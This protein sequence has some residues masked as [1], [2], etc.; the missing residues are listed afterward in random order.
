MLDHQIEVRDVYLSRV[1]VSRYPML[2]CN[3]RHS[4]PQIYAKANFSIDGYHH[5]YANAI[6]AL[7]ADLA[8][9]VSIFDPSNDDNDD[10]LIPPHIHHAA[11]R[12]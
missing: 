6:L 5:I 3:R 9:N 1:I 2:S 8:N 10:T 7:Y 11:E 4:N 12:S